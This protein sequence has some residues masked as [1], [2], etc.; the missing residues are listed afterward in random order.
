MECHLTVQLD[1]GAPLH[2]RAERHVAEA[3]ARAAAYL[4]KVT[5]DDHVSAA[6]PLMPCQQLWR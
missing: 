1:D 4:A 3:F 5:I 2:Y 6:M